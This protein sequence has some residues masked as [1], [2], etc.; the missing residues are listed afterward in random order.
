MKLFLPISLIIV[1]IILLITIINP[2][3]KD[4]STYNEAITAYN[5]AIDSSSTLQKTQDALIEKYKNIKQNDKD[6][7]DHFLPN[8]I[9]NIKFILEIEKIASIHNL[10]IMNIKF[11]SDQPSSVEGAAAGNTSTTLAGSANTLYGIF[12][13]EFTVDADYNT[14]LSF[15]KDLE[16]NLRLIDVQTISFSVP[17]SA[18]KTVGGTDPNIYSYS[19][20]VQTYWLK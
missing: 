15:L 17:A 7:L 6:R 11:R 4:V 13:L 8:T 12:P 19:L 5:L 3:F 10:Q 2:Y 14:F 18:T 9:N 16:L 1:S 20:N